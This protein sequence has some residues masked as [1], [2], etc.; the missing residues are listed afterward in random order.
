MSTPTPYELF[1]GVEPEAC[2]PG[3]VA[4]GWEQGF[5]P[6]RGQK[7]QRVPGAKRRPYGGPETLWRVSRGRAESPR[8]EGPPTGRPGRGS[9]PSGG[10]QPPPRTPTPKRRPYE[11]P[12]TL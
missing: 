5:A 11:G 4:R 1:Q 8:P 7:Y 2:R 10:A 9:R 12:D 6:L 3:P